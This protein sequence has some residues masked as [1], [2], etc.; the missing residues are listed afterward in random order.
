MTDLAEQQDIRATRRI[1]LDVT[2]MT[3]MMCARRVEK[4]LNKVDGVQASVK[5]ATKIA[6]VDAAPGV[7]VEQ[8]C[9][10]VEQAGYQATE[11]VPGAAAAEDTGADDAASDT[12]PAARS[13]WAKLRARFTRNRA[14]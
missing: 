4:A 3:C 9:E 11:H 1:E 2:G 13:G 5:I 12:E 14:G 10:V 8:L 6:T 7:T